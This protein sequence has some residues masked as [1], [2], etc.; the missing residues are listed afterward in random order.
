MS[1]ASS[2]G[3]PRN[4]VHVKHD[5][6]RAPSYVDL[7]M[8]GLV[9]ALALGQNGRSGRASAR[10]LPSPSQTGGQSYYIDAYSVVDLPP[11]ELMAD[12]PEL[13]GLALASGQEQLPTLL[14][15]VGESVTAAYRRITSVVANE[16]VTE[17]K[18]GDDRVVQATLHH[19]YNYLIQVK[20]SQINDRLE[21]YR[22]DSRMRRV[23]SQGVAEGFPYTKDF[24]SDWILLYPGNQSGSRFRYLGTESLD[25]REAYVL[26]FAE[27]AGSAPVNGT[28]TFRGK[29][30]LL[31]Y[32]GLVWIDA[33]TYR[34]I[35]L[36]MDLLEPRLDVALEKLTTEI[37]LGEV[38]IPH[39]ADTLWLPHD[40]TVTAVCNGQ[41]FRIGHEYSKYKLFVVQSTIK[42]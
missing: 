28:I 1:M 35:K 20:G 29:S 23:D 39:F 36:R 4:C 41:L 2:R 10:E 5:R 19:R 40:V 6:M 13:Q 34:V 27:R 22:A 21:E 9:M 26:A 15:K 17:E 37:D 38:H 14:N 33:L 25:G 18:Y 24:A 42:Y 3:L 16:S 11:T 8:L 30:A 12:F 31:L 7:C 32:Q